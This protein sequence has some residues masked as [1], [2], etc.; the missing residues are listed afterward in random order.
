MSYYD[1]IYD[2][3][4]THN[5]KKTLLYYMVF[6]IDMFLK[7]VSIDYQK[8]QEQRNKE[9]LPI[10]IWLIPLVTLMVA[11]TT[12]LGFFSSLLFYLVESLLFSIVSLFYIG[13]KDFSLI[14]NFI[15]NY[16]ISFLVFSFIIVI[17]LFFLGLIF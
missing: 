8:L 15:L 10:M 7:S 2:K 3:N 16:F 11:L 6:P 9:I 12:N 1:N 13:S 5:G 4:I 17:I 14:K